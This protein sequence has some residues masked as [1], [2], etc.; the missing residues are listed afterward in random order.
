[1]SIKVVVNVTIRRKIS[2]NKIQR[3]IVR[4]KETPSRISIKV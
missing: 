4:A 2:A 1:M 3:E